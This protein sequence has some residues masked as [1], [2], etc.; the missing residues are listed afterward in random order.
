[1]HTGPVEPIPDGAEH[2][3]PFSAILVDEVVAGERP[4]GGPVAARRRFEHPGADTGRGVRRNAQ[5]VRAQLF[6]ARPGDVEVVELEQLG[7]N[8]PAA[9]VQQD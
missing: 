4:Q 9:P 6:E 1:L 3:S 5:R 2:Q 8:E 7:T